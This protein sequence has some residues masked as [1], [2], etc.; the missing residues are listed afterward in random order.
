MVVWRCGGVGGGGQ[1]TALHGFW[2]GGCTDIAYLQSS[3]ELGR[4]SRD[5]QNPTLGD[6]NGYRTTDRYS[7]ARS[8]RGGCSAPHSP[9][10]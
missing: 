10:G 8:H 4:L 1:L 9:R 2:L 5:S 3:S 7:F 6:R